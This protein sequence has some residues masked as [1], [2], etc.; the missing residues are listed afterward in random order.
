[1]QI[2]VLIGLNAYWKFMKEGVIRG[3]EGLVAQ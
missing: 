1:M 3:P 2:D